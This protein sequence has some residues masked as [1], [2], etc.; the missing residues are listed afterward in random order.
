MK[1]WVALL[2]LLLLFVVSGSA[3]AA[4][5][6]GVVAAVPQAT[7]EK[8]L[9]AAGVDALLDELKDGLSDVVDNDATVTAIGDKWDA[10]EDLAGKTRSQILKILFADIRSTVA[11]KAAQTEIWQRWTAGET[12]AATSP[13]QVAKPAVTPAQQPVPAKKVDDQRRVIAK[14]VLGFVKWYDPVKGYGYI[15]DAHSTQE[16]FVHVSG[17][18]SQKLKEGDP[19]EFNVVQGKD[20]PIAVDVKVI[21]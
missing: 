17:L 21:G 10:H 9:D 13:I 18:I 6:G 7:P 4:G 3:A 15:K 12:T 14:G 20:G 19:V 5:S 1:T 2:S 16:Y 8:P 11:D